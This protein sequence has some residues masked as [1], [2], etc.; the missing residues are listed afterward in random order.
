[1]IKFKIKE[2]FCIIKTAKLP[3]PPPVLCPRP[4]GS[5]Q[6]PPPPHYQTPAC[7]SKTTMPK[8][9]L[10]ISLHGST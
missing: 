10:D 6:H 5:S 7:F 4:T 1:M 9:C 2:V 3:G 8:F